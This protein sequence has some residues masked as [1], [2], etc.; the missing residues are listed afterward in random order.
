MISRDEI[1]I[2]ERYIL[3]E[4]SKNTDKKELEKLKHSL[5]TYLVIDNLFSKDYR[6]SILIDNLIS[7]H[8][9][10][11]VECNNLNKKLTT[12]NDFVK[13]IISDEYL[14]FL[15]KL[16]ENLKSIKVIY[17]DDN[18]ELSYYKFSE[19][20]AISTSYQFYSFLD[21]DELIDNASVILSNSSHYEFRSKL[22]DFKE[23]TGFMVGDYYFKKSYIYCTNKNNLFT[24]QTFN[25]EIMHGINF[26]MRPK[27]K[28]NLSRYFME[29]PTYTIDY[30]FLDF[31]EQN[32]YNIND[33]NALRRKKYD[34]IKNIANNISLKMSYLLQLR[35]KRTNFKYENFYFEIANML[36]DNLFELLSCIL[37]EGLYRQILVNKKQG[38]I[39]LKEIMKHEFLND[40]P[41]D[42]SFINLNNDKLIQI[43]S[44]MMQN[45]IKKLK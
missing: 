38:L 34:Y 24:Y 13:P 40:M 42:F 20:K 35:Y 5:R 2:K 15:L 11:T 18:K 17:S 43:S 16:V 29:I 22:G 7:K 36:N 1:K 10:L 14:H 45:K 9:K 39:N 25:H 26:Y 41:P 31:L 27:L 32:N 4:I 44:N 30:L 12:I 8:Y 33:I 37:A 19:Y 3:E 6:L 21:D 23:I 28:N